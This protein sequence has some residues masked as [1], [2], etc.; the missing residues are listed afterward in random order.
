MPC[1]VFNDVIDTVES[2]G[3]S[4][5]MNGRGIGDERK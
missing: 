1:F 4:D 2:D 3:A 5:S